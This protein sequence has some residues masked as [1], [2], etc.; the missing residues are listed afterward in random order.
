MGYINENGFLTISCIAKG[1]NTTTFQWY[2]DEMQIDFSI[3]PRGGYVTTVHSKTE[4][5]IRSVLYYTQIKKYDQGLNLL[6][7]SEILIMY[8]FQFKQ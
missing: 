7:L 2:K 5:T 8:N 1:R 6:N 4:G 3:S